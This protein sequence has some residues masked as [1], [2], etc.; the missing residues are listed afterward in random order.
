VKAERIDPRNTSWE[1]DDPAYRVCFW[2]RA[3]NGPMAGWVSDEWRL[4]E[5]DVAEV[6]AWA[7]QQ[8]RGRRITVWVEHD[9]DRD[10]PS[11]IRLFGWEP[12]RADSPPAWIRL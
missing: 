4:S 10:R 5:V 11:M 7:E 3:T 8:A 1:K 12:T 6:L 2:H 9:D